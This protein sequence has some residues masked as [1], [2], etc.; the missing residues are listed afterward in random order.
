MRRTLA[1][2]LVAVVTVG[3][4]TGCKGSDNDPA[5]L[6]EIS[7]MPEAPASTVSPS[8][9][10]RKPTPGQINP[11]SD[12]T[13]TLRRGGMKDYL[14]G[15]IGI[16]SDRVVTGTISQTI[17]VEAGAITDYY[18]LCDTPDAQITVT[19]NDG[20]AESTPCH[21]GYAHISSGKRTQ[22][23]KIDLLIEVPG[24]VTYEFVITENPADGH[25]RK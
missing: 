14:P 18:F 23:E 2:V 4:L 7:D 12:A 9:T 5:G 10:G 16:V 21:E 11:N 1:T 19:E 3:A 6:T 24:D 20:A 13:A 17:G 15:L 22:H 25:D 8:A